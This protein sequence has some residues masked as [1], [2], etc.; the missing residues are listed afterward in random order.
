L[1]LTIEFGRHLPAGRLA[2]FVHHHRA[3]HARKLAEYEHLHRAALESG[4]R[5][6]YAI[7]T[8]DFGIAHERAALDWF[9]QL[10]PEIRG[11]G[12]W[13]ESPTGAAPNSPSPGERAEGNSASTSAQ[14]QVSPARRDQ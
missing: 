12:A 5:D 8:L 11:P 9:E 1:L 3:A 10:P 13:A 4:H 14:F 7:A 2:G 6:P